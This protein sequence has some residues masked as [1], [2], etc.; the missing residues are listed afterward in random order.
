MKNEM[1]RAMGDWF[2]C[3]EKPHVKKKIDAS[4]AIYPSKNADK[5]IFSARMDGNW[6][7]SL[8]C[9]LK[10]MAVI[11]VVMWLVC[12]MSRLWHKIF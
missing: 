2:S 9:A 5:A 7:Y 10:V 8:M 6:Q 1:M 4:L 3:L 11:A 12:A